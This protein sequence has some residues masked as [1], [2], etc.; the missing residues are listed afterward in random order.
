MFNQQQL[1]FP[2][3]E[4]SVPS[5]KSRSTEREKIF[6]KSSKEQSVGGDRSN[7]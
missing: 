1:L 4:N 2:V 3:M 6:P 7:D 5:P